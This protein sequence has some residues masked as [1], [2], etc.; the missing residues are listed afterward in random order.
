MSV[1]FKGATQNSDCDSPPQNHPS[2]PNLL[3]SQSS[4]AAQASLS[5]KASDHNIEA[6]KIVDPT[7]RQP[8]CHNQFLGLGCIPN[9][10][11]I[12]QYHSSIIVDIHSGS[13]SPPESHIACAG[14]SSPDNPN[15]N[16]SQS[17]EQGLQSFSRQPSP[18][19]PEDP[20]LLDNAPSLDTISP[21]PSA[22][23]MRFSTTAR[24][25]IDPS[26]LLADSSSHQSH[27]RITESAASALFSGKVS[28]RNSHLNMTLPCNL[29]T[30]STAST[31]T[32]DSSPC[33]DL[34]FSQSLAHQSISAPVMHYS[35]GE[36]YLSTPLTP[37]SVLFPS[38]ILLTS[39]PLSQSVPSG[40]RPQCA[41][42]TSVQTNPS[43]PSVSPLSYLPSVYHSP[44]KANFTDFLAEQFLKIQSLSPISTSSGVCQ[45]QAEA[46]DQCR[47]IKLELNEYILKNSFNH[48]SYH[49]PAHTDNLQQN[50]IIILN[51][52]I[53]LLDDKLVNLQNGLTS[54]DTHSNVERAEPQSKY[55]IDE[56]PVVD[57][58]TTETKQETLK[59]Y[60]IVV[61]NKELTAEEELKL[62]KAQVSDFA[63]VCKAVARGDL[64]QTVTINVQGHDLTELK[65]VVNGMVQQLRCFAGE[66][67][68]VSIEVG[69]EGRLGGQA[70]VEG[71][72]GAWRQL[73]DVVNTLAANLSEQVRAIA[74]VTK[75]IS[76]GD[77][78]QKIQVEAK[79]EVQ[80]LAITINDM[81]DQLRSFAE[82]VS[83]VALDVGTKGRLGGQ[84]VVHGVEGT[85]KTLRDN[86]N[87]MASNLTS[88]VRSIAT[89][90]SAIAAG[91]LNHK[92]EVEVMGEMAELKQTVNGMVDKLK[93][94]STEVTRVALETG[95]HG[96]LGGQ[97]VVEGVQGVWLDLTSNV[98]RMAK[99]LTDQVR[100]IAIVTTCVAK[101]DLT[102]LIT[103]SAQG[104]ILELKSTVNSM[105]STLRSFAEEVSRVAL[106]VGTEGKLGGKAQ[107]QDVFGTWRTLTDNV[108][109]MAHNLTTQ[110]RGIAKVTT[111][112]AKGDLSQKIEVDVKGEVLELKSTV[113][114]MVDSLRLFASEVTRVAREVG[115]DGKLGGRANVEGVNGEWRN[116]TDCV[117][118]MV[119]RLTS[120]VRS[121]AI[122][123]TAVAQ[124]DLTMKVDIEAAGEIAELRDT[125]NTMI[126]RLNIFAS[127]VGK[128]CLEVGKNGNLGVTAH[129]T[130]IDGTW[131]D[132][133]KQVNQMAMNLTAQVR[134][135]AQISSAAT[136]G[137]FSAFVTV[138]ASGEMNSLKNQINSM[139]FS[140]RDA[141][142]KNTAAREAAEMANRSKSE[143]LANMS[144]EIRTPMNGIIGMTQ[145]TLAT[146]LTRQQRENLTIVYAMANNLLLIIDDVL[147]L[148]KIEAGRMT[149]EKVPFALRTS[150]F[151]VLKSLAVKA[152]TSN[153]QL[154]FE[155]APDVPDFVV[156]DPFRMRQVI[157]NLI[158]N[159]IK[160]TSRGHV[161]LSCKV[162]T[163]DPAT[164]E[165]RLEFC[166]FDTGIGIKPDKLNLIFDTFCQADGSTTRKYGGTGLGL[167]ISKRL[168]NLM[169]GT[170][171]VES[172]YN[173]GSR[174]YFT[175]S[176]QSDDDKPFEKWAKKAVYPQAQVLIVARE[177]GEEKQIVQVAKVIGLSLTV[178][179]S[180]QEANVL[181]LKDANQKWSAIIIDS[182]ERIS[183]LRDYEGLRHIPT[184]LIARE[185][186]RLDI[187]VCL[188]Y[189]IANCIEYPVSPSNL[190]N[191]LA[192]ALDQTLTTASSNC[193]TVY[194]I[195]LAEDNHVNQKVATKLL[196]MGG[197][198]VEVVDN[199]EL[200]VEAAT[201]NTYD[202]VL[203][204]VSMPTMGGLEATSL[205]RKHE[206]ENHLERVPIIALTAHAMLGDR[207]RCIDA[208]MDDYVTKPLRKADLDASMSR[209][210]AIARASRQPDT[211]NFRHLPHIKGVADPEPAPSLSAP[212]TPSSPI[213][214]I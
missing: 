20:A 112:V 14:S 171:W 191:A 92:I 35:D 214:L 84:A 103:V 156:G 167:T 5:N 4:A 203:M 17:S 90:T 28:S 132:L 209:C 183:Q 13:P 119:D 118:T 81:T 160:F 120:Q 83:R 12:K 134:A 82:E 26:G 154:V 185:L 150:I 48:H 16:G 136:N 145:I 163:L 55:E 146:E 211:G 66:V 159:A 188:D 73:T 182:L 91:D 121:I 194:K 21:P 57:Y 104:E 87:Q 98:N 137:D 207:E 76:R 158:G 144:H 11:L 129:V 161:G 155:I 59:P 9:P 34:G 72:E 60:K 169:E 36:E 113:N 138:E 63:R 184:V 6:K 199:G 61:N 75:S 33:S 106:E 100:E 45:S 19:G 58:I 181:T 117:N 64:S 47:Q 53:H 176:V 39:H 23:P 46:A 88:Q 142:Q 189:G 80:E 179:E 74:G 78:S 31:S 206:Q 186:P 197:H 40:P 85:W 67:T 122:T 196:D 109:T 210:V 172:E 10:L 44:H 79:G 195:L 65:A 89:V 52:L 200:A 180:L 123:T 153:L 152:L 166:V 102:R 32:T 2:P 115:F 141:L 192:P 212:P 30:L 187:K 108:N 178:V 149:I 3:A 86:V 49:S 151:D 174:F 116:L 101:G 165:H 105:V 99:N 8:I 127:E 29:R 96:N 177:S 51:G 205:I 97:A 70:V 208:G 68:R 95:V 24:P 170:L 15:I 1:Y 143:F 18:C 168:V 131:K 37:P 193:S 62:L 50:E 94:F 69:T 201:K 114:G 140:L 133:T 110:V 148:S 190:F 139:V 71:A 25:L 198:K 202:L 56:A 162:S 147:D 7:S 125:V 130:D 213:S 54:A 173:H 164:R 93:V 38:S 77:L 42:S 124:G 157:T 41:H 43:P 175:T 27:C 22:P 128:V 107:V 126:D 135:F 204:D 111:A